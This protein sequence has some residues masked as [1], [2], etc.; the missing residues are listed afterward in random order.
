MEKQELS[1][2]DIVGGGWYIHKLTKSAVKIVGYNET[3]ITDIRLRNNNIQHTFESF[4][5]YKP[6]PLSTDI[7][8][9]NGFKQDKRD[10]NYYK[11]NWYILEDNM[12]FDFESGLLRIF[13]SSDLSYCYT[14]GYVHEL[15]RAI[16][17][18]EVEKEIEL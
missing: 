2:Q 3:H 12:S 6:I 8:V 1:Y 10:K 7:L 4:H 16:I 9:K 18:C 13:K 14:I 11:W 15:Q 17:S 5:D